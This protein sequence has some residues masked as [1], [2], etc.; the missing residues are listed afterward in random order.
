VIAEINRL[1]AELIERGDPSRRF[2]PPYSTAHIGLIEGGTAKNVIPRRCVFAWETRLLPSAEPQEALARIEAFAETRAPALRRIAPEAGIET[3]Q[4]NE[5]PALKPDPGSPAET[6]ALLLAQANELEAVS[7]G[8]EAGLFQRAGMPS[9]VCGPGSIEQA[10]KPNEFIALS[11]LE[12]CD[13]FLV[14]LA[15]HCQAASES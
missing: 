15:E 7:Y 13:A 2:D 10:H 8:T 5:V 4:V 1:A 14:R 12:K 9:I 6:L 3:R 11:E